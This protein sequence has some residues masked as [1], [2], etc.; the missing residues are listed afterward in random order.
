[1]A[2]VTKQLRRRVPSSVATASKEKSLV[3]EDE[4]GRKR[5]DSNTGVRPSH[6]ITALALIF[7]G[8]C[9]NV[10][11]LESI[12][13]ELPNAGLLVTFVQFVFVSVEGLFHFVEMKNGVPQLQPRNVPI[14]EWVIPV[15]LFFIVSVLNNKVWAY[16]VSVPVHIV[17]RS[18]G[19]VTT[20]LVGALMGKRYTQKQVL[21][22]LVLTIGVLQATLASASSNSSTSSSDGSSSKF[23]MGI[24][25]LAVAALLTSFQGVV[26]EKTYQK[27]GRHWRESLFYTHFLSLL[28]FVPMY[29]DLLQQVQYV[30]QSPPLKI[31][32][33]TISIPRQ[34]VYLF[35]N[36]LTQYICVRGVNNLAAY[37]SA[38]T[39]TIVLNIRKFV[40][41]II[42]GVVFGSTLSNQALLGATLV[43]IGAFLYSY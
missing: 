14:K 34:V 42:S 31:F 28:L 11:T 23:A 12:V 1:M 20:M 2:V 10:C 5:V 24:A 39:V 27:Y 9:S 33:T 41:L 35:G 18:S 38:L 26:A 29:K 8:C 13:S 40:S 43:F 7:G 3:V 19:T 17:F 21:S 4:R 30:L 32:S 37:S 25:M 15:G 36:A 16:D 22:V 6:V